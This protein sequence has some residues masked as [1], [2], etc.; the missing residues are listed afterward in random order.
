[1]NLTWTSDST[2][3]TTLAVAGELDL[4]VAADLVEAG[5]SRIADARSE[6]LYLD[7]SGVTFIDSSA[8]NAL[9]TIRNAASAPVVLIAPSRPVLR[10]LQL[11]ALDEAFVIEARDSAADI[12]SA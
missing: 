4:A 8:L 1:V 12:S 3:R 6:S 11:T 2:G 10:L 9:I 7:L 5:R